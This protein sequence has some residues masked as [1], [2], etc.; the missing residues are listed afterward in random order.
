MICNDYVSGATPTPPSIVTSI[1]NA[2]HIKVILPQLGPTIMYE[3]EEM[4][5]YLPQSGGVVFAT[6]EK[7]FSLTG[8]I[9]T[10]YA[11]PLKHPQDTFTQFNQ[12][13]PFPRKLFYNS[14]QSRKKAW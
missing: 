10:D 11:D 4:R 12:I 2:D 9:F 13:L 14:V 5:R 8:F 6:E 1:I 7:A 3:I